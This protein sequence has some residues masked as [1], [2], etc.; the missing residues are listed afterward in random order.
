ML[1]Y[2]C[3]GTGVSRCPGEAFSKP[4]LSRS[5]SLGKH[6]GY[7]GT[8]GWGEPPGKTI[9]PKF[10]LDGGGKGRERR[11][12]RKE[13]AG[14]C[15]RQVEPCVAWAGIRSA[16]QTWVNRGLASSRVSPVDSALQGLHLTQAALKTQQEKAKRNEDKGTMMIHEKRTNCHVGLTLRRVLCRS[17][18]RIRWTL[19]HP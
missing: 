18:S 4:S 6:R 8:C 9:R 3:A 1:C 13:S 11:A 17:R 10:E 2:R 5:T 12:S 15:L 14:V 16:H 19:N 7:N